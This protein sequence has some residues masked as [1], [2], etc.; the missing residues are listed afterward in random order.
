MAEVMMEDYLDTMD[1]ILDKAQ[2]FP[3]SAKKSLVDV[4]QLRDCID[5]IR[6]N[7]PSEVKQAKKIVQERKSIIDDA[8]KQADEIVT[9]AESRAS[10]LVANHEIT[11]AAEIRAMEIEKQALVKAKAVKDAADG[12]I[13]DVLS[14][15]EETLA[16]SL[17]A[18]R[19][20]K[21][22]IKAPKNNTPVINPNIPVQQIPNNQQ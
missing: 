21:G 7:I 18:V 8:N 12:Y 3:L 19:R 11:K 6:M 5:H 20:T 22:T 17:T 15:T 16:A 9:R 14:K 1:D 4:D 13:T 2:T 10:A